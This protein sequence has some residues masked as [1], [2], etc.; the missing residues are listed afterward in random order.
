MEAGTDDQALSLSGCPVTEVYSKEIVENKTGFLRR[1]CAV[2]AYDQIRGSWLHPR[3][4]LW[5]DFKK[6]L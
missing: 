6:E 4:L 2:T 5:Q 1:T 3:V